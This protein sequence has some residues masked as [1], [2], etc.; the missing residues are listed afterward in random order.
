MCLPCLLIVI[1]VLF[2]TGVGAGALGSFLAGYAGPLSLAIAI[3][4]L[5]GAA[6]VY[7]ISRV[8]RRGGGIR[9]LS[10]KD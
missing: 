5:T 10:L 6:G 7:L 1:A 2:L 9:S 4:L 3:S 8:R